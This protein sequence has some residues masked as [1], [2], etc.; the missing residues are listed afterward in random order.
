[1]T[2]I[3]DMSALTGAG[4]DTAA[5][6]IPIVDMSATGNTRNKTITPAELKTALA[7]PAAYTLTAKDEGVTLSA[8][9][10]SLDFTGSAV[11]A[12][13]VGGAVSVAVAGIYDVLIYIPDTPTNSLLCARLVAVRA[14][15]LPASLTGSVAS[16]ATAATGSTTFTLLKNGVSFATCVF[17]AAGTTGAFTSAS[18][19]TFAATDV[20]TVTAPASPDATLAN[21]SL[22]LLGSRT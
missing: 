4:V 14:F 16:A 1:M 9:T 5:D 11:V 17:S 7:V 12:T 6:L 18:G 21:I 22:S 15:S 8:A 13:N 3:S 19:A 10:T 20:L 2:K